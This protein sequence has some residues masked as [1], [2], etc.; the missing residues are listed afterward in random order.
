MIAERI[1]NIFCHIIKGESLL[2]EKFA[3][4]TKRKE[5]NENKPTGGS[6][7][8]SGMYS[9]IYR[10]PAPTTFGVQQPEVNES[11]VQRVSCYQL[12]LCVYFLKNC[13]N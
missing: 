1:L 2:P 9:E 11:H 4:Q 5:K 7:S 10:T 3:Q 8:G 6:N 12:K 13:I